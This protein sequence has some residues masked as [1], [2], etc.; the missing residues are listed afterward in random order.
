MYLCGR[1]IQLSKLVT[2]MVC[3]MTKIQHKLG[4][5]CC[6]TGLSVK[7]QYT[8]RAPSSRLGV[9]LSSRPCVQVFVL[10]SREGPSSPPSSTF[11]SSAPVTVSPVRS[12]HRAVEHS[13]LPSPSRATN[14]RARRHLAWRHAPACSPSHAHP[15]LLPHPGLPSRSTPSASCSESPSP[16]SDPSSARSMSYRDA[17]FRREHHR[18]DFL[19]VASG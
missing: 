10:S 11:L 2:N 1:A 13:S 15:F 6:S 3:Y 16:Y 18:H 8:R 19:V 4:R 5:A 17:P 7:Q 14:E 12:P 9:R